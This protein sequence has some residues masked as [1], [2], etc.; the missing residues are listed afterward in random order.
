MSG[1]KA[2]DN[3]EESVCEIKNNIKDQ[4]QNKYRIKTDNHNILEQGLTY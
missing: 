3:L 4:S 1:F 2:K